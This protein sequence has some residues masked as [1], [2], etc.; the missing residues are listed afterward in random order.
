M[1]K[2]P[3]G[4]GKL[5][6][7]LKGGLPQKSVILISGPTGS[8]KTVFAYQFLI[9]G[10]EEGDKC[11]LV[12][13][14]ESPAFLRSYIESFD[15]M[16]ISTK[17]TIVDAYSASIGKSKGE[18]KFSLQDISDVSEFFEVIKKVIKENSARRVVVDSVN[19]I[20]NQQGQNIRKIV[21]Q[22]KR[23]ARGMDC[24][25]VMTSY[26]GAGEKSNAELE[27]MVD[28]IIKLDLEEKGGEFRRVMTVWKMRFVEFVPQKLEFRITRSGIE[29]TS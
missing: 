11:I 13:S 6:E 4:I 23:I 18:E 9:K 14:S 3:T 10:V 19:P 5:D 7:L 2:I 21:D 26:G 17:M 28:G 22:F 24:T 29:I 12:S 8:G 1:T 20:L 16:H 27:Q 25:F 15:L